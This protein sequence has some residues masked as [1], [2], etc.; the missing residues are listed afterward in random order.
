MPRLGAFLLFFTIAMLLVASG[1]YYVWVRLVRDVAWPRPV[2]KALTLLVVVLFLSIPTTFFLSRSL[3]PQRGQGLLF[4]LYVWM[5][6]VFLLPLLLGFADL[7][8]AVGIS[9]A[10]WFGKTVDTDRRQFLQRAF[11]G[12]VGLWAFGTTAFAIR[13]VIRPLAVKT[14]EVTLSKLPR[15]LGGLV[16][17]QLTDL[18]I[19][20]TLR[21]S[22][23]EEVVS[24]TNAMNPDIIAI[25]GD[26]VDGSV[27]QLRDIVAPIAQLRAKYGVYFVTGNHEYY[28][29]AGDWIVELERLGI[30]VL[31]NERV[32]IGEGED[33]FDLVGIDDEHAHQVDPDAGPDLDRALRGCD[34]T[35]EVVLLAHQP[36][37]V[38]RAQKHDVGLQLSGHTHGGQLWPFNWLVLLQ[39][40][41]IAGLAQFG[42]TLVYVSCGTGYWGP[43]MRLGAPA[44]ITRVVLRSAASVAG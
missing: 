34:P 35:R 10:Q 40:P 41:V 6:L 31:R 5:G 7:L 19:G 20:P 42:R 16:I 13:E 22:F 1:H 8:R 11:A 26:L 15:S 3:P 4:V 24:R 44:E 39:Q 12:T 43:P 21:G 38:H 37:A 2:H 32:T 27:A 33:C 29:G 14:V 23:V 30:R 9:A 18:H 36:K 28:S 25:T 17:A